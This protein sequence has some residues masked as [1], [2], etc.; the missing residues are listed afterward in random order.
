MD[1]RID[2]AIGIAVFLAGLGVLFVA[3]GIRPTGPVVD[4]I[5]P[6]AFPYMIGIFFLI[7]GSWT[8]LGRLRSWKSETGNFVE[9]EGEPDEPDVPASALQSFAVIVASILYVLAMPRLGYPIAT[10]LFVIAALKAMRMQ[11]W[12]AI[13]VIALVYTAAT[14][15]IFAHYLRVDLPL[16]P[17]RDLFHSL[18]LSR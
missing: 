2:L 4:A 8:V 17:L 15:I 3:H 18:G 9:S 5:G 10:P 13:I 14:Y 12:L 1:R 6:R 7:G 11:S 16:G